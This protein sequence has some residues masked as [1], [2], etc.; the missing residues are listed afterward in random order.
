MTFW[1]LL[2]LARATEDATPAPTEGSGD[3]SGQVKSANKVVTPSPTRLGDFT[4]DQ[5]PTILQ[6]FDFTKTIG[7]SHDETISGT[8]TSLTI[9]INNLK[10]FLTSFLDV[11]HIEVLLG[12][13]N[14]SPLQ[15]GQLLV[16][17]KII[18]IVKLPTTKSFGEQF[19]L[20]QGGR[21]FAP[22][23]LR[24]LEFLAEA[25][26]QPIWVPIDALSNSSPSIPA[27]FGKLPLPD[28]FQGAPFLFDFT[29]SPVCVALDVDAKL[30]SGKNCDE[31]TKTICEFDSSDLQQFEERNTKI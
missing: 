23:T 19:C 3:A 31:N 18:L 6:D 12:Q 4:F 26:K 13:L 29:T 15:Q 24:E 11:D 20:S 14:P 10:H 17:N 21:L 1:L 28:T 8:E 5:F 16:D 2:R 7:G 27:Y 22:V 9:N 25:I 30:F